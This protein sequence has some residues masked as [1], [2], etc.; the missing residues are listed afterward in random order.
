MSEL[1]LKPSH[2]ARWLNCSVSPRLSAGITEERS[3]FSQAG[4]LAHKYAEALLIPLIDT[5][6]RLKKITEHPDWDASSARHAETYAG[7]VLDD[8]V[9]KAAQ[10]S[11][12]S[13]EIEVELKLSFDAYLP[14]SFGYADAVIITHKT[15]TI[16]D[17]KDGR[18]PVYATDN[19]Q[20]M[21]YALGVLEL[22]KFTHDIENVELVIAQPRINN[23][24]CALY[25]AEDVIKWAE[26]VLKPGA[27]LAKAG[28]SEAVPGTWCGYC[29]AR[30]TC[31]VRA[32]AA[33]TE[34]RDLPKEKVELIDAQTVARHLSQIEFSEKWIKD[35][36]AYLLSQLQ[37]GVTTEEY[38]LVQG[39]GTRQWVDPKKV[40][41]KL[42]ALKFKKGE[43]INEKLCGIEDATNLLGVDGLQE[44]LG[45]LIHRPGGKPV[46]ALASDKRE[47][48][49]LA[50]AITAFNALE[51]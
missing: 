12:A 33:L 42:R 20:A 46:L 38:K 1:K 47:A 18:T 25:R 37:L 30:F 24:S 14:G 29:P 36:R 31:A 51:V 34:V 9:S 13:I 41:K 23:I 21:I 22:L 28:G 11:G 3:Q 7:L 49:G 50:D 17:F 45:D 10:P 48:Y 4:I 8:Y 43:Y 15:I 32:E 44:H 26:D 35:A 40:I 39:R 19:P 16:Y 27:E 5:E 2:A 6:S